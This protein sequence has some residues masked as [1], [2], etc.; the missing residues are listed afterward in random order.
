[1]I[2]N[3]N[4]YSIKQS[5]LKYIYFHQK[6]GEYMLPSFKEFNLEEEKE[7]GKEREEERKRKNSR[8]FFGLFDNKEK[9]DE[10]K[11]NIKDLADPAYFKKVES[12]IEEYFSGTLDM[13]EDQ[14]LKSFRETML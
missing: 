4:D 1:M 6:P 12:K 8:T 11:I 9:K 14:P 5:A 13:K 3:I 7:K 10:S 2:E